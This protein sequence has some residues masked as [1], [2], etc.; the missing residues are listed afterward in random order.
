MENL[1]YK[2]ITQLEEALVIGESTKVNAIK[3]IKNVLITGMGGS[4]IAGKFVSEIMKIHGTVPVTVI[5]SYE[6]PSWVD[7]STLALVSSYSGNT[8][9]TL[10]AYRKLVIKKANIIV[11]TSGGTVMKMAQEYGNSV[12]SMPGDWGAP[13]ACIG[14][15][16]VFQLFALLNFGLLRLEL[17]RELSLVIDL[18]LSERNSINHEAKEIAT[19]MGAKIP[20]IYSDSIF[21]PVAI[22]FRQQLNENSKIHSYNAVFPEMNHNEIAAWTYDIKEFSAVFIMSDMYHENVYKRIKI[23]KELMIKYTDRIID[24]NAK[25]YTLLQQFF[26]TIHLTDWISWFVARQRG[27]DAMDI[28][29]IIYLKTQLGK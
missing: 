14:Y 15:S 6:I 1:I 28:Q 23:S 18:L 5:N 7:E 24:I 8:E 13:R 26:Y 20:L 3:D 27:V 29:N 11:I 16:M 25:G 4:G 12:F 19:K 21:E 22:R 10:E 2:F 17:P 9:E